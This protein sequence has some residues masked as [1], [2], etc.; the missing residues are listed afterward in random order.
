MEVYES[1]LGGIYFCDVVRDIDDLYCEQC[2]DTDWHLG[3]ADTWDEVMEL[4][5]D[6]DGWCKYADDYLKRAKT[7]FEYWNGEWQTER[8]SE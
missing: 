1:H 2:G 3:H 7:E 5:T 8:S 4:I 6:E